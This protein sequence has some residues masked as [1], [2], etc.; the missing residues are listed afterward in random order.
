MVGKLNWPRQA[1]S[2]KLQASSFKVKLVKV[3]PETKTPPVTQF[4][5]V[6]EFYLLAALPPQTFKSQTIGASTLLLRYI[7]SFSEESIDDYCT[8]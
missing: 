4:D 5:Y 1:S 3:D 6:I 7:L 2:F 8:A